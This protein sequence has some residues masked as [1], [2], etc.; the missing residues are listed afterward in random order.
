MR[1]ACR[2][3]FCYLTT[4]GRKSGKPHEIE[5]WFACGEGNRI[6][7]LSGG[8]DRSDWV[9]NLQANRSVRVRFRDRTYDGTARV[10]SLP[11]EGD[12]SARKLLFEKYSPSESGL[13][14][15]AASSLA[16]EITLELFT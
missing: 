16:I 2:D 13:E 9:R 5:I 4:I 14:E 3:A 15:W 12:A 6:F 7:M 10:L 11:E 1:E 8:G